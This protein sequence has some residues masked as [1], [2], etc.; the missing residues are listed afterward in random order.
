MAAPTPVV[1]QTPSGLMLRNGY[2][3]LVTIGL[4][5]DVCFWEKTV[6]PP[7]TQGGPMVDNTTMWNEEWRTKA[8]GALKDTGPCTVVGAYDPNIESMLNDLVNVET[9]ITI[10][11]PDGSTVARYGVLNSWQPGQ[12]QENQLP[13]GTFS[14]EFTN[15][16]PVN[17][18][19]A[20]P[21]VASAPG[22]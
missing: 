13:E 11:Y 3:T 6:Q 4:D 15:W 21:A 8:P 17:N 14:I 12:I 20:G 10:R 5:P 19:E 1:R 7:Q 9:T 22:T 16:D 18:V 2:R